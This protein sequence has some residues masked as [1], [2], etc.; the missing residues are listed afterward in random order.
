M[1]EWHDKITENVCKLYRIGSSSK[2]YTFVAAVDVGENLILWKVA[3]WNLKILIIYSPALL[4]D[5]LLS[6]VFIIRRQ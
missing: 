3:H 2:K 5:A 4:S 6:M 1:L